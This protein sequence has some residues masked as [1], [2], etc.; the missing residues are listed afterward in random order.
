MSSKR[1]ALMTSSPLRN[2]GTMV[3]SRS[4]PGGLQGALNGSTMHSDALP[5]PSVKSP[6]FWK[7][8]FASEVER[9]SLSLAAGARAQL[10]PGQDLTSVVLGG[11]AQVA[12]SAWRSVQ[13]QLVSGSGGVKDED[14]VQQVSRVYRN[15]GISMCNFLPSCSSSWL[16][17]L[18]PSMTHLPLILSVVFIL[19]SILCIPPAVLLLLRIPIQQYGALFT[20]F[21]MIHFLTGH[22]VGS[23]QSEA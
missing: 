20:L 19:I 5:D 10:M 23:L 16:L 11:G 2:R 14:S 12:Q 21:N 3:Q 8:M 7:R 13:R 1:H 18:M 17:D 6:A 4:L 22:H 15:P 9:P